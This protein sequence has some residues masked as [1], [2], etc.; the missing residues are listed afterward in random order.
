MNNLK[1]EK[2]IPIPSKTQGSFTDVLKS[3]ELQDSV[4]LECENSGTVYTK[5][6]RIKKET[7]FNF[8]ARK[9]EGGFRVWRTL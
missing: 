8:T 6:S 9:V 2:G 1:I 3:M 7:N 5:I 4:Y